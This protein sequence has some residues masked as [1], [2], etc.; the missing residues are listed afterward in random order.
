VGSYHHTSQEPKRASNEKND[1]YVQQ[2]GRHWPFGEPSNV[3]PSFACQAV[4]ALQRVC[5]S[6]TF[7]HFAI[8]VKILQ[9][10][11]MPSVLGGNGL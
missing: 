4:E 9:L 2:F 3:H 5:C 11:V 8:L 6:H 7:Q 1:G 10:K